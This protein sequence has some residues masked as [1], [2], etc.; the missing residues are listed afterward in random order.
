MTLVLTK[1]NKAYG[2]SF[3]YLH[4]LELALFSK[5]STTLMIIFSCEFWIYCTTIR[6]T[7]EVVPSVKFS[8][9]IPQDRFDKFSLI[10][11]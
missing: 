10:I 5:T 11:E 8:K 3:L 1:N 4:H 7:I 2:T 6:F 9:Y